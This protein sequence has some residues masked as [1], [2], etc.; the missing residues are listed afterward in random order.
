M[1]TDDAH[2]LSSFTKS[3]KWITTEARKNTACW[4]GSSP[5]Y[6]K[7]SL[8]CIVSDIRPYRNPLTVRLLFALQGEGQELVSAPIMTVKAMPRVHRPSWFPAPEPGPSRL[9]FI[10]LRG[11]TVTVLLLLA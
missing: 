7:L 8:L 11:T 2:S 4:I 3:S 6:G 1:C 10:V 5:R 9:V